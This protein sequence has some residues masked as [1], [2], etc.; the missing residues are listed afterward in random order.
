MNHNK[1]YSAT[2]KV[3]ILREHFENRIAISDLCERCGITPQ[4]FYLWKK[5]LFEGAL[6]FF[7]QPKSTKKRFF[8]KI[9]KLERKLRDR[10]SLITELVSE[11]IALKKSLHGDA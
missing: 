1:R 5:Q 3:E 6:D 8:Q 7:D 4:T 10:D 2:R 11:N 9:K